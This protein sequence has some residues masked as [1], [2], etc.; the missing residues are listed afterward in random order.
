M[1]RGA[2]AEGEKNAYGGREGERERVGE[3]LSWITMQCPRG[4]RGR[5][6]G[7]EKEGEGG[8]IGGE[9]RGEGQSHEI[10]SGVVELF[11]LKKKRRSVSV[12]AEGRCLAAGFCPEDFV[13]KRQG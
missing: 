3:S 10:V 6:R 7:E 5:R 9:W 13:S 4:E 8:G 2:E 1:G 11:H 12:K